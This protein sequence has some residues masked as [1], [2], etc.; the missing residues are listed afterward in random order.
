VDGDSVEQEE[1]GDI[2]HKTAKDG[3]WKKS[4]DTT[5]LLKKK[6]ELKPIDAASIF[7]KCLAVPD[8]V[9]ILT[10]FGRKSS[11]DDLSNHVLRFANQ[12]ILLR[13]GAL[14]LLILP[15]AVRIYLGSSLCSRNTAVFNN[16]RYLTA[17]VLS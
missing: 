2:W 17:L 10:W 13:P 3:N 5:R 12:D 16:L 8:V 15:V 9:A 11:A 4:V 14:L 1:Y 7:F 6:N